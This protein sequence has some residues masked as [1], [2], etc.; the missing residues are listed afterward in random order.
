V[1]SLP[2]CI[3]HGYKGLRRDMSFVL[4]AT[5][6]IAVSVGLS[7]ALLAV[8][9]DVFFR[10]V[11]AEQPKRIVRLYVARSG[12]MATTLSSGQLDR[13]SPARDVFA[14][15][16]AHWEAPA[17][18]SLDGERMLCGGEWVSAN[19][20]E[21][22]QVRPS[23]GRLFV[24]SD[25]NTHGVVAPVVI[26]HSFW[27]RRLGGDPKAVGRQINISDRTF[28][29]IGIAD[30][31]F[32]GWVSPWR[33]S[34]FWILLEH[35]LGSRRMQFGVGVFAR[36]RPEISVSQAQAFTSTLRHELG[37]TDANYVVRPAES[38]TAPF[39]ATGR[40]LPLGIVV[41]ILLAAAVVV[42][43]TSANVAALMAN[44]WH[45]QRASV[46]I[47]LALGSSRKR[48]LYQVF[49]EAFLVAVPS[50]ALGLVFTRWLLTVFTKWAPQQ[51][52]FTPSIDIMSVAATIILTVGIASVGSAA[53]MLFTQWYGSGT[54]SV[55]QEPTV[56]P[57]RRAYRV[58]IVPQLALAIALTGLAAPYVWTVVGGELGAANDYMDNLF[59]VDLNL[60]RLLQTKDS[61]TGSPLDD[62]KQRLRTTYETL[63]SNIT[64]RYPTGGAAL[65]DH[66]PIYSSQAE[67]KPA[68]TPQS[69]AA[70]RGHRH[71][72]LP[73]SVSP[74]YFQSLGIAMVRGRD[75]SW[76]DS[77]GKPRVA[78]ISLRAA[79][80]LWPEGRALGESVA[81]VDDREALGS[82]RW[83]SV[84][85]VV[86]DIE[87]VAG[88]DG[89]AGQIY[90]PLDQQA[91]PAPRHLLV[92]DDLGRTGAKIALAALATGLDVR[93]SFSEM[94][95]L[96]A[97]IATVLY[98]RRVG[99]VILGLFGSVSI[100]IGTIGVF[101]VTS[102]SVRQRQRE[103]A[104]RALV[105]ACGKD[106]RR[107]VFV[108]ALKTMGAS[109][110]VGGISLVIA[111]SILGY[112]VPQ[113]TGR[114]TAV[115]VAVI[116]FIGIVCM[117]AHLAPAR[118]AGRVD[119][120]HILR[121]RP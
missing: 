31:K 55:I 91:N 26:S 40:A 7:A 115:V 121:E 88:Q 65:S 1:P 50:C 52:E 83:M 111:R 20:F 3:T 105:G 28:V 62:Q 71:P 8:L 42:L 86:P 44:R 13:L 66:L 70:G 97:R 75:F 107:I 63:R 81:L 112:Y 48:I 110:A 54:P 38:V 89:A 30:E 41:G 56:W 43:I 106:L 37:R 73:T 79:R 92:V 100:I 10:T 118:R 25:E 120:M 82:A 103:F 23:A 72:L 69:I 113:L 95:P 24:A 5:A 98:P 2:A 19:Y 32:R 102:Y 27:H 9:A 57:R 74:G 104:V 119:P 101:G 67:W 68:A 99:A 33:P 76:N 96:N 114:P 17:S 14:G 85:G 15:V 84:V 78:I 60:Q 46:A 49:A 80:A 47:R 109:I 11:A 39:N 59:V 36:L 29:V 4:T 22:L 16:A 108:D 58:L 87:Y 6:V 21:V 45:A 51:Y 53:S 90:I 93:I 77:A 64:S 116:M 94:A 18:V 34:D 61:S 35:A 12:R 117:S